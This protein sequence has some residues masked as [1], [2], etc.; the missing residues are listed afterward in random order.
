MYGCAPNVMF[1]NMHASPNDIHIIIYVR[2]TLPNRKG[3][4]TYAR[5]NARAHRART[6]ID[7]FIK[8]SGSTPNFRALII[9]PCRLPENA[10]R[11]VVPPPLPPL[12]K[13]HPPAPAEAIGLRLRPSVSE[14]HTLTQRVKLY[15]YRM[16]HR[17]YL[18]ARAHDTTTRVSE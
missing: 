4:G 1:T 12:R 18:R 14:A 16:W 7:G 6:P 10:R 11:V 15:T 2:I 3:V 9:I 5:T 17:S 13:T 8:Y